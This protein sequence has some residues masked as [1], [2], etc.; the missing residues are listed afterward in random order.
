MSP[1]TERAAV[2]VRPLGDGDLDW[3]VTRNAEVYAA[4]F[5]W[6][7]SYGELVAGIVGDF[8]GRDDADREAGWIAELDGDRAGCV[9]CCR[10]DENTAQLRILLVEPSARGRGV[11]RAL[12]DE[13]LAFA[14]GAGYSSIVLWTNDVLAAARRI[15]EAVGFELVEES[16]HRSFGHDLV[17]QVW[18]LELSDGS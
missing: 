11:G 13:C 15:Y 17:G 18:R 8:G 7:E 16:P 6:D 5:G 3:M 12:V 14:R 4:E 9:L 1:S 10:R 2:A